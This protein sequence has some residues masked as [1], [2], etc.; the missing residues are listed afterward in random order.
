MADVFDYITDF[1]SGVTDSYVMIEKEIERAMVKGVLAPAKNL[2]INSIKSNTK[3]SMTTSGT[4]IKR[5]LNQVGEQLDGSI[6]GEFSSKVV[7]TLGEES[8]RY[9]KLFDK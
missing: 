7:R 2:S 3:Q 4:A 1:F 6:K 8:K 5:S 9:T